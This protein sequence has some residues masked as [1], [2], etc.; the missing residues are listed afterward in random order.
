[1][2]NQEIEIDSEHER[3]DMTPFRLVLL[4]QMSHQVEMKKPVTWNNLVGSVGHALGTYIL[5]N[6]VKLKREGKIDVSEGT[7]ICTDCVSR[8]AEEAFVVT[9]GSQQRIIPP[10]LNKAEISD[11]QK[12]Q[13]S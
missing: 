6:A 9:E 13:T 10:P 1:M 8:N 4:D 7:R 12:N 3:N 2:L 11:D 5:E